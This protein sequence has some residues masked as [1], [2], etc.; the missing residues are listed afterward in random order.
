MS[1]NVYWS[2]LCP[3]LPDLLRS[4]FE[5]LTGIPLWIFIEPKNRLL[6]LRIVLQGQNPL[7][8]DP[9]QDKNYDKAHCLASYSNWLL[10]VDYCLHFHLLNVFTR[11]TINLP[12]LESSLGDSPYRNDLFECFR[13]LYGTKFLVTWDD[14]KF[15]KTAV[16]WIN[17]R[18]GD[19]VVAWAIEQFYIF[20]YKKIANDGDKGWSIYYMHTCEDMAY[21]DNKLYVYT[22]DHYINFLDFSGDFP[23]ETLEGNHYLNHPFP[24]VVTIYKMRIAI[25]NSGEVMIF[26][27][28]NELNR[29]FCI[30]ELNLQVGRVGSLGDQLLISGHGVTIRGPVK[31]RGIKSDSVCLLMMIICL[32]IICGEERSKVW[33]V[34]L[35]TNLYLFHVFTRWRINLP[36]MK[37]L[38]LEFLVKLAS[39]EKSQDPWSS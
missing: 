30:C 7:L 26:L 14:F 9:V 2:K 29:K 38:L 24:F 10:I 25:A 39:K 23:K 11:E 5:S 8:Y 37:S 1:R 34:D 32:I 22:Y 18:N 15:S 17:E 3:N 31:D 35:A 4:I 19:F 16:L 6:K 12:S 27:S 21:K 33:C 28:L 36:A 20:S 13:E